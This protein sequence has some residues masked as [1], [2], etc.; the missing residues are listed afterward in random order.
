MECDEIISDTEDEVEDVFEAPASTSTRINTEHS[1]P[2][3][4]SWLVLRLA[5]LRIVQNRLT[6]FLG[7]AGLESSELPV[8][9]P[10]LHSILRRLSKW[11]ETLK[12]E[13]DMRPSP[14]DYIPGCFVENVQHGPLMQKYRQLLEPQNTPFTSK[15]GASCARHLW[16]YLVH[17]EIVRDIFIRAVFGKRRSVSCALEDGSPITAEGEGPVPSEPVRIIHKEQDSIA[18]FSLNQVRTLVLPKNGK[19]FRYNFLDFNYLCYLMCNALYHKK[20]LAQQQRLFF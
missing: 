9:S 20:L 10:L 3:S 2:N 6:D 13:L 7:V 8:S 18:A 14:P 1:D 12:Y 19:F 5:T 16:M 4:Y 11:Q 15:S 17:Q